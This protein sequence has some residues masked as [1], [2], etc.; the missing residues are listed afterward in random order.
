M[1]PEDVGQACQLDFVIIEFEPLF[2][3]SALHTKNQTESTYL[4]ADSTV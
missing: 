2:Y 4:V 1:G 3:A